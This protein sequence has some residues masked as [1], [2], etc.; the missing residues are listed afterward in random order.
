MNTHCEICK[1]RLMDEKEKAIGLC[2]TCA[3]RPTASPKSHTKGPWTYKRGISKHG[4]FAPNE[5]F[6]ILNSV[7]KNHEE[8]AANAK[9]AAAAPDL[10]EF[11]K[12]SLRVLEEIRGETT[13]DARRIMEL[14]T[15]ALYVTNKAEKGSG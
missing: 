4:V 10:Y 7:N 8:R 1:T 3:S 11:A 14:I 5:P 2:S 15:M 13:E 12:H 9:L 6:C